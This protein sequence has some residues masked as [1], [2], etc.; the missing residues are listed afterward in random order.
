MQRKISVLQYIWLVDGW[1]KGQR[2]AKCQTVDSNVAVVC[3][4]RFSSMTRRSSNHSH[5]LVYFSLLIDVR[6]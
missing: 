6:Q 2:S 3:D 1:A 5:E 4:S